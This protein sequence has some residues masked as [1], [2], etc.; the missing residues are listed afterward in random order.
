MARF[1]RGRWAVVPRRP[2][3][4]A[5]VAVAVA[6][7]GRTLEV[8]TG[9]HEVVGA[10]VASPVLALLAGALASRR[11][12]K[13]RSEY[14][15]DGSTAVRVLAV[16]G[17]GVLAVQ[18]VAHG[19]AVGAVFAAGG[20][21]GLVIQGESPST[22]STATAQVVAYLAFGVLLTAVGEEVLFRGALLGSLTERVGFWRANAVQAGLFG[23]WHLAWP[24][25]VA[26]GPFEPP[27]AMPVYALG[28][29]LVPAVVGGVL[30][31]LVRA[32]GTLWTGVVAHA[33]HNGVAL[34]VH[35]DGG[36]SVLSPAL[37][38][39]YVTLGWWAWSRWPGQFPGEGG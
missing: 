22:K 9:L 2:V 23:A 32:T 1:G 21:A 14:S 35:V 39:G 28:F 19:L 10:P 7:T 11:A 34:F 3:A 6:A 31:V 33:V 25:A 29:V 38:L 8:L 30:G 12:G 16:G 36:A 24:L 5:L 20:D 18:V 4:A 37:V 15:F 17:L 13:E 26:L 27:V